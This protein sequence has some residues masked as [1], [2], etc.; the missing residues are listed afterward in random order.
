MKITKRYSGLGY[1]L[2]S[3]I[4]AAM[5]ATHTFAQ[6]VEAGAEDESSE[7]LMEEVIVTG[8]YRESLAAATDLKRKAINVRDSIVE[9]DIGKFH[10]HSARTRCVNFQGRW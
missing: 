3:G 4:L 2:I 6:D 1:L 5:P 8:Q 7:E 9:E 10:D